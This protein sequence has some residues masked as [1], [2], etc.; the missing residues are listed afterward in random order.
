VFKFLVSSLSK[1]LPNI[2]PSKLNP[3]ISYL[4][5]TS[6][7]LFKFINMTKAADCKGNIIWGFIITNTEFIIIPT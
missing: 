2:G 1:F 3:N 7:G 4:S 5:I 6:L